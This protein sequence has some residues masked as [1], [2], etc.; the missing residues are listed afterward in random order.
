M[1]Q[2]L[3]YSTHAHN[4]LEIRMVLPLIVLMLKAKF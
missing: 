2:I 1:A 4:V 3:G